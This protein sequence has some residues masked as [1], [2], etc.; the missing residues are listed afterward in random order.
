MARYREPYTLLRHKTK[1]GKIIWYYRLADDPGR[2]HRSTGKTVKY[3]AKLYVEEEILGKR[4][5]GGGQ[6]LAEY[7]DPF[8]V[9]D[10]CPHLRR[11]LPERGATQR[12]ARGQRQSIEKHILPDMIA[13]IPVNDVTRG[14]VVSFRSRLI[15]K[16]LAGRTVNG[17]VGILK[18]AYK[19]GVFQEILGKDPTLG[20]GTVRATPRTRGT[21]TLGELRELFPANSLGPWAD[22]SDYC[23]FLLAASTGARRGEV[24]ALRWANVRETYIEIAEAWKDINERGI[25]K[26]GR[27]R[28]TPFILFP[29]LV[30]SRLEELRAHV[31]RADP[32]DLL[33]CYVDGS[34]FGNTWWKRRWREGIKKAGPG[35]ADRNLTPHSF[36]HTLNSMLRNRGHDPEAIREALGW[37]T[38]RSQALY[39]HFHLR[40]LHNLVLEE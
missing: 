13:G 5:R 33:F 4:R 29:A 37:S 39:T 8:F 30:R 2:V 36:R 19:E 10:R 23:A 21:F 16:G 38:D 12:Y 31:R 9:W 1:R 24:L 14:D 3:E 18:I 40:D 25:P 27:A 22:F 6:T 7:L 11:I 15:R 26:G 28:A 35:Y 34:R 17:V 20:V 32:E